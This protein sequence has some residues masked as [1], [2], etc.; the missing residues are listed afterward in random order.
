MRIIDLNWEYQVELGGYG[1]I[2][3]LARAN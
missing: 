1:E 3:D 2:E